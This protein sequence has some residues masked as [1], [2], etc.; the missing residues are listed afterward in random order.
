MLVG[1]VAALIGVV[2]GGVAGAAIYASTYPVFETSSWAAWLQAVGS[3]VAIG[4][5]FAFHFWQLNLAELR[6]LRQLVKALNEARNEIGKPATSDQDSGDISFDPT[7]LARIAAY[8]EQK[9]DSD[10][11]DFQ[12]TM[13]IADVASGITRYCEN[14]RNIR[15][16]DGVELRSLI[17]VIYNAFDL[18]G[19]FKIQIARAEGSLTKRCRTLERW[20][21]PWQ[22][23]RS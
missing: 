19:E 1:A 20:T 9:A 15:Q 23:A 4:S 13:I 18:R 14:W 16:G 8:I 2:V 12:V 10:D 11:L 5:G 6:R 22:Q 21:L 17:E 7:K 3:I